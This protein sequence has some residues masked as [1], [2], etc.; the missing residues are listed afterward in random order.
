MR[1]GRRV[2]QLLGAASAC[3]DCIVG[4]IVTVPGGFVDWWDDD[5]LENFAVWHLKNNVDFE[6]VDFVPRPKI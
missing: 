5:N 4:G 2:T 3:W 6:I 1:S